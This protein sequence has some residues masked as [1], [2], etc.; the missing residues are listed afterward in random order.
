MQ[1][2]FT[3]SGAFAVIDPVARVACFAY[4][5]SINANRA[6]RSPAMV[7]KQMLAS[8]SPSTPA[9]IRESNYQHIAR[10]FN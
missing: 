8:A 3:Q 4:P 2:K 5:T 10:M 1:Y 9:A 6:V 7:A